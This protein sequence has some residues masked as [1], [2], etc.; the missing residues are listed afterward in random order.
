MTRGVAVEVVGD[1]DHIPT[2]HPRG[3]RPRP[4]PRVPASV[5]VT[6]DVEVAPAPREGADDAVPAV[7]D[8]ADRAADAADVADAEPAVEAPAAPATTV[9]AAPA[10]VRPAA[11]AWVAV[12]PDVAEEFLR[13]FHAENPAAGPVE[14]RVAAVRDE[15]ARTGTYVHTHDELEFGARVA[16][17]NSARCIGR[18]YWR[19]LHLRDRRHVTAPEEVAS[20]CV[21]HLRDATRRG[22]IRSTITIF[23]PDG[24]AG[25]G[26]RVWNEQLIRYAGYRAGGRVLG[27]PRYVGFT[28]TARSLGWLPPSPMGRFDVLP[29]V[30]SG[31]GEHAAAG[32]QMHEVPRDAVME[33]DLHHPEHTWFADLGLRWHALPVISNMRL[34]I[35]GI[36]YPAAPFNGWYMATEISARN[37]A[38]ADR[39]D[40]LAEVAEQ[41]GLDTSSDRTLWRDRAAIELTSA[42]QHSF[43]E[44]GV[45]LADHHGESRRFLRF[46]EKE[47]AAG[48]H[49]PVDW[50]WIVPP[51]SGG[52]TPVF[53][54]YYD[55][56]TDTGPMF[57]LDDQ[58]KA[59]GQGCPV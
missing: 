19:S 55:E 5:P 35:G 45:S 27:D 18:L 59:R 51:I 25:P 32:P 13:H 23:A 53:H 26:P 50:S 2:P 34:D 56:P 39:Y 11:P 44:A 49:C 36:S 37:L 14:P 54:R 43:D 4:R 15:I 9:E 47:E 12:D 10:A 6:P 52:L 38:D 17:R 8:D 30:V 3:R 22:R 24:P 1:G 28:D 58:A 42:V 33:V 41:M 7:V 20:E 21:G 57:R 46:V 40:M 31:G 48:R 16:W 29:L